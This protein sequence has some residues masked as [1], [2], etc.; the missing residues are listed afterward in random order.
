[1]HKNIESI[2]HEKRIFPP[3]PDFSKQAAFSSMESY[4]ELYKASEA[5]PEGFWKELAQKHH[6]FQPFSQTLEW[7]A[8]N[9]RWF[10]GGTTNITYNCLDYQIAQGKGEKTALIS[11][12]E[13]GTVQRFSYQELLREVC[14]LA[15]A[16]KLK[17][18]SKGDRVGI[19]MANT[20]HAAIAMLACAR[21]GAVHTVVF[22][23]F[24]AKALAE[25]LRDCDAKA[26]IC[27]DG[28]R[29]RGKE[30]LLK[31]IVDQA[32]ESTPNLQCTIVQQNLGKESTETIAMLEG[33][34]FWWHEITS[35][36]PGTLKAEA[37]D[38]EHP[39]FLLYTSGTTG[40]PKGILH[41]TAGYMVWSTF[42]A[43]YVFDLKDN[44]IFFCTA[45]VGWITGH[46][47]V[48]YGILA[49]GGTSL[50]YEG[51]PT[52]P[53]ANRFW[54]MIEEHGVTI[55]YTAPTAI[56]AFMRLGKE[57]PKDHDL[58]SL[59]LLGSVG[60]PI[61]PE[62]WKWYYEVIGAGKT[63][64]VDTWWQTETGGIMIA[65]TPGA[66]PLKPGSATF[67][68]PGIF[69]Q[70]LDETDQPVTSGEGGR[71]V[72]TKPWPGMLRGI[73][74]DP[75]RFEKTYF[76]NNTYYLTGDAAY[77]DNDGYLWILGRMDDVVNI[78]GHRLGTA[79]IESALVSHEAVTEAAVVARPD[80]LTGQAL[81]AFVT[82]AQGQTEST[83]LEDKLSEHVAQE[84]GKIARPA[85]IHFTAALPKTRSGKIMRRLLRDIACGKEI[86]GD[87]STL[88]D[89]SALE[90]LRKH[91]R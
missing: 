48:V 67:P 61:N 86:L 75:E 79:E 17:N 14:L 8:P 35:G 77:Y 90:A 82:L 18:I 57:Y 49:N 42:T 65:P 5:D 63:P 85:E 39:L 34:D 44:D 10:I 84:I 56:R 29:R 73:Y 32:L 4:H 45:D 72:I 76:P 16:L 68:L 20:A 52:W 89:H 27:S 51:A 31:S 53:E 43:R 3:S 66:T 81:S 69:P 88:E 46:S 59:R 38:S 70:I 36:L 54:K 6:W 13:N 21:I 60:E 28:L 15:E 40:K 25:R 24:S 80:E 55:F 50:I 87:T 2:Q 22:G 7:K 64:I 78:S 30:I 58:S 19:Y 37:C 91:E 83:E 71:L 74:G 23:G 12:L 62:A 47:Y 41:T 11:E 26:L 33:R 9:A 1:M